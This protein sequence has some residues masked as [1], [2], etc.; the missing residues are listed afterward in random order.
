MIPMGQEVALKLG[1]KPHKDQEL[2]PEFVRR[3]DC[4]YCDNGKPV[5]SL[6]VWVGKTYQTS[7]YYDGACDDCVDHFGL[8]LDPRR[9][10]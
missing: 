4:G 10:Y 1:W 2:H 7:E 5:V 8:N 3:G 6:V 9:G